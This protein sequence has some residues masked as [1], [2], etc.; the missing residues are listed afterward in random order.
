MHQVDGVLCLGDYLES[1]VAE[2]AGDALAHEGRIV[3]DRDA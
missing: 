1:G 2:D 3:S